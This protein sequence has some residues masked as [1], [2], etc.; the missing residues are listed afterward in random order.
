[1]AAAGTIASSYPCIVV[2]PS[3]VMARSP[4]VFRICRLLSDSQLGAAEA[5]VGGEDQPCCG[6]VVLHSNLCLAVSV[7]WW[8]SW[9]WLVVAYF[10]T[11]ALCAC[12]HYPPETANT[13]DDLHSGDHSATCF[14]AALLPL[15]M[16]D[17][18]PLNS[19]T[20]V[21]S[22]L[23]QPSPSGRLEM[24]LGSCSLT[25]ASLHLRVDLL[26][27]ATMA[28]GGSRRQ[29]SR[30]TSSSTNTLADSML[31]PIL[32]SVATSAVAGPVTADQCSLLDLLSRCF[33]LAWA[34]SMVWEGIHVSHRAMA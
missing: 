24:K 17:R 18:I 34:T 25:L 15:A 33:A 2:V 23:L 12:G 10:L 8:Y 16:A 4:L 11:A 30:A 20:T 22:S 26:A 31:H 9:H 19:I 3:T 29:P 21:V 13:S 6:L 32:L 7:A 27:A 5:H 1:M 28:A 14:T